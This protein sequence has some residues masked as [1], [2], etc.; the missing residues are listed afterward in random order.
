MMNVTFPTVRKLDVICVKSNSHEFS[1]G[2]TY[3]ASLMLN[4]EWFVQGP[5]SSFLVERSMW[6]RLIYKNDGKHF[7]FEPN[8]D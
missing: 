8:D 7:R 3:E 6:G 4:G 5:H 2:E 1:E